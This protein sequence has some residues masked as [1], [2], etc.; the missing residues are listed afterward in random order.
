MRVQ[1]E[2][3][4]ARTCGQG[5]IARHVL[6]ASHHRRAQA[7]PPAWPPSRP[8][9]VTKAAALDYAARGGLGSHHS[10]SPTASATWRAS[11]SVTVPAWVQPQ[12][13]AAAADTSISPKP[14]ARSRPG[15]AELLKRGWQRPARTSTAVLESAWATCAGVASRGSHAAP[16]R[17]RRPAALPPTSPRTTPSRRWHSC[18]RAGRRRRRRCQRRRARRRSGSPRGSAA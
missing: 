13:A 8:E 15:P 3:L 14:V 18:R 17:R 11:R 5:P 4:A 6:G 16:P 12:I 9:G 10:C 7:S 2:D 1:S